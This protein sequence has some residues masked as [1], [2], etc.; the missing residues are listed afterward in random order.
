MTPTRLIDATPVADQWWLLRL[1]WSD[2][3]PGIGQ[4]LWISLAERRVCLPIRDFSAKEGWIAGVL[5][6]AL[7]PTGLGPGQSLSVSAIQGQSLTPKPDAS[8]IVVGNDIG[9]GPAL[10]FAE[11]HAP[12]TRLVLLGGQYGLPAR[13]CPSR[14]YI[15][16]L[17]D[18]AIAGVSALESIGVSARVALND[19]RPGVY[20]GPLPDLLNRYISELPATTRAATTVIAFAAWPEQAS[21]SRGL[22]AHM[23]GL[24]IIELPSTS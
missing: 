14:F 5:P 21:L 12:Q 15:P 19:D 11:R 16:A 20:A 18:C 22:R 1:H 4:W 24:T 7:L 17:A 2:T 3:P 10:G 6:A 8:V 13:L 23:A 9:I